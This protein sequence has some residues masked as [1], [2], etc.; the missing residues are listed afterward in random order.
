MGNV[1][2][3][4]TYDGKDCRDFG[5]VV[6]SI[7]THKT[8]VRDVE[9]VVVAGRNGTLTIDKGR[10]ENIELSYIA[11]IL[12]DFNANFD[13]F[14]AF[15]MSCRGYKRLE[16]SFDPAYFRLAKIH[17]DIDPDVITLDAAGKFEIPF[18]CDPR[19]FLKE[20]EDTITFTASGTIYNPTYYDA[21]PLLRVVGTGTI[22]INGKVITITT[23]PTYVMIDLE[24]LNAYNGST[25]MNDKVSIADGTVLASGENTIT[26]ANTITSV[27][28]TPRWWTI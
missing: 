1:I 16:D 6:S 15:L 4:L 18:N 20:G 7:G 13:A 19:R 26:L 11:M 9:D 24:T 3:Y 10:F 25:N 28:I 5:V 17:N 12:D 23:N 21:K 14:K 8:P 27:D 22:T 2:G